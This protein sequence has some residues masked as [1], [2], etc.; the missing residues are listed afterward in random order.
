MKKRVLHFV[1]K[2]SQLKT[3]FIK[4]QITHHVNYE[5]FIV[6]RKNVDKE[7]D[8]G[9]AEFNLD[10]FEYLDL[11]LNETII[12]KIKY[13]TI[14][15][16]TKRQIRLIENFIKEKSIDI[17]H[18]HYGTDCGVFYPLLEKIKIPSVVSF[19]G[20]DVSF[21]PNR[22]LGYGKFFLR[23]RVFKKVKVVLAMTE[24]MK[25]D[26][27]NIGC[28]PEK[29][30]VHYHGV[31][32]EIFLIKRNNYGSFKERDFVLLNV[33]NYNPVKG[34]IFIFQAIK[35]LIDHE[36]IKI[37]LRIVGKNYNNSII[38]DFI[39]KNRLEKYIKFLGPLKYGS[40]EIVSEYINADAFIHPSVLQMRKKGFQV[41]LWKP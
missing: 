12:E 41:Q 11:S 25:K 29:I 33:A 30:I 32:S 4:N 23:N 31:P 34:H 5:P 15:T 36:D 9:F 17:C 10:L 18:F 28:P 22:F 21:F 39:S 38:T 40:R 27:I 1:R 14:R 24:E 19:Y 35:R 16:I 8:G 20:Y 6:C 2:S 37:Q 3:S 26:L 7:K 13:K